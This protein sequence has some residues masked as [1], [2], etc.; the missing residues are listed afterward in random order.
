MSIIGS[1]AKR[2]ARNAG[3]RND[4]INA[5][6]T[7]APVELPSE[8]DI[9]QQRLNLAIDF[10]KNRTGVLP[11]GYLSDSQIHLVAPSLIA[12]LPKPACHDPLGLIWVS[13]LAIEDGRSQH[14]LPVP[15]L[16]ARADDFMPSRL[17][18]ATGRG[19]NFRIQ[20]KHWSCGRHFPPK[21]P[22]CP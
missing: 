9:N 19:P 10:A 4:W 17:P 13:R 15:L 11:A 14:H 1:F 6:E 20:R 21:L 2:M 7:V 5:T 8:Y 22:P 3:A 12:A 18:Q 16:Y